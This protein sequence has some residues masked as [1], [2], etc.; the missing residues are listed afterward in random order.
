MEDSEAEKS[1]VKRASVM[2]SRYLRTFYMPYSVHATMAA[3]ADGQP[4]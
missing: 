1:N 2:S 4:D 3:A